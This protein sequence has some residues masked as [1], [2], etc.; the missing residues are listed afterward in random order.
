MLKFFS[1][2]TSS[3]REQ[4]TFDIEN[5]CDNYFLDV[6]KLLWGLQDSFTYICDHYTHAV[7]VFIRTDNA[8]RILLNFCIYVLFV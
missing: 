3:Q 2:L 5:S 4:F 7:Y 6:C 1:K 8:I